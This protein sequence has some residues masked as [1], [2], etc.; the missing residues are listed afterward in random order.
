MGG[1]SRVHPFGLTDAEFAVIQDKLAEKKTLAQGRSEVLFGVLDEAL[2]RDE[3][4][5]L[6]FLF[7]FIP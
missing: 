2:N 5:A 1:V 7:A 3:R 4:A 6:E